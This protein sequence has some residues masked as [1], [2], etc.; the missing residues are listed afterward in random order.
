MRAIRVEIRQA[1]SP[2]GSIPDCTPESHLKGKLGEI[3]VEKWAMSHKLPTDSAFEVSD[4]DWEAD[5]IINGTKVDVKTWAKTW[6]PELG[7]CLAVNQLPSI[8]KK[9][10]VLVW[11]YVENQFDESAQIEIAGWSTGPDIENA[12]IQD[13]G[14]AG[15]RKVRNH[16]LAIDDLRPLDTLITVLRGDAVLP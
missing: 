6:W 13:T 2:V 8:C 9:A 3:A 16:Q 5:L 10:D 4:R 7:R 1:F 12:P 15:K 11:C 14:P